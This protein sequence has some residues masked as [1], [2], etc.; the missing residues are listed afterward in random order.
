MID[1]AAKALEALPHGPE[2]RFLDNLLRLEPGKA[3]VGEYT[4]RGNEYF[5][6]GHFPGSPLFPGVLLVE[7]SAQLA[8]T[9][10]QTDP[11]IPPMS[12]L[13]LTA[14]RAVKILGSAR[15]GEV[16]QLEAYITGRL[17][18]L[19]QAR[20][21]ALVNKLVVMQAEITL[22]GEMPIEGSME[23]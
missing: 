21:M 19:V 23:S 18:N 1:L 9:V 13:K 10:A 17:G 8:G 11:D 20:T 5:L 12:G 15:P 16:I 22:S 4:V 14:M 2:F 3:G 7:A 6:K